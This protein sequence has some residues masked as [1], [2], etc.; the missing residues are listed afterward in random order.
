MFSNSNGGFLMKKLFLIILILSSFALP[1]FAIECE[2][3]GECYVIG[4]TMIMQ[5][6]Y[7]NAVK[8]FDMAISMD[9]E[10]AYLYAYRAKANFYLKKFDSMIEDTTKSIEI[11]PNDRA[12][13]LRGSAK[14]ALGD[15][16]GA[17]EDT[18]EALKLNP[19]YM[20]CYEVRARAEV[21]IEDY[22]EALKD[23]SKAIKLKDD[24]AKSYE[25]LAY[26]QMGIKDYRSAVE[27]FEKSAA[28][29]K[30]DKD[31]QNYKE[32]QQKIKYCKRLI[33]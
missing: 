33:K 11:Y 31:K 7:E 25:V 16:E 20:K 32:M 17:I 10:D 1:S 24:Y 15:N 28:L 2:S 14:L 19:F 4:K 9:S 18:T 13:G 23:I 12:Y 22:I 27:S 6:E 8:C 30:K 29:F 5:K 21:N 26:A 3:S